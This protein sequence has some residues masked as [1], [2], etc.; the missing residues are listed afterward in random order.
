MTKRQ[1]WVEEVPRCGFSAF[2]PGIEDSMITLS[3]HLLK[4]LNVTLNLSVQHF[5]GEP[6]RR[7]HIRYFNG[8]LTGHLM[9]QDSVEVLSKVALGVSS[10]NRAMLGA[11]SI[12]L[13]AIEQRVHEQSG[14]HYI[15]GVPDRHST[16]TL[17]EERRSLLRATAA[18]CDRSAKGF[19][20]DEAFEITFARLGTKAKPANMADV[21]LARSIVTEHCPDSLILEAP[22]FQTRND[23]VFAIN[24]LADHAY[25]AGIDPIVPFP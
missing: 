6:Y 7:P 8:S 22:F 21:V 15:C 11:R 12:K 2:R 1:S 18:A 14:S 23:E 9:T 3:E 20:A 24:D 13:E 16:N 10:A 25:A 19:L 5:N 4:R 17:N